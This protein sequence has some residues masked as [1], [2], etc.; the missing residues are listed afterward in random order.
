VRLLGQEA[1]QLGCRKL[2]FE[3]DVAVGTSNTHL[4]FP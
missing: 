3:Q 4:G 2:S 1:R